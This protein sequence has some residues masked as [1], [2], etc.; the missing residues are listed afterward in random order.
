MCHS[1]NMK[2]Q[3]ISLL[4][5]KDHLEMRLSS[6]CGNVLKSNCSSSQLVV[7]ISKSRLQR[8]GSKS[9]PL[10]HPWC[11]QM[12]FQL[13]PEF[14]NYTLPKQ[15]LLPC[16]F[17]NRDAAG[18]VGVTAPPQAPFSHTVGHWLFLAFFQSTPV[19]PSARDKSH[20]HTFPNA[21]TS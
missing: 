11:L 14:L 6:F 3:I 12:V 1:L 16:L 7:H 19:I 10:W 13:F 5:L 17:F 21:P 4:F 15:V 8:A 18:I 9:H 2:A 20:P